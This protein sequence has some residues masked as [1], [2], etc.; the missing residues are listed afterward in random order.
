[1]PTHRAAAS[2]VLIS[3]TYAVIV[4]A[5]VRMLALIHPVGSLLL[6]ECLRALLIFGSAAFTGW[7]VLWTKRPDGRRG[8]LL[9]P[10]VVRCVLADFSQA[11]SWEFRRWRSG[12]SS[13]RR[14]FAISS[15]RW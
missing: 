3:V 5:A 6:V 8:P 7:L 10:G 11:S 15:A 9:Q 2:V 12:P 14:T 13:S 4:L 1:M